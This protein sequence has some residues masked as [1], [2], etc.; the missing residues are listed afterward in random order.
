MPKFNFKTDEEFQPTRLDKYLAGMISELSRSKIKELILTNCVQVNSKIITDP[1]YKLLPHSDLEMEYEYTHTNTLAPK[2]IPLDI[3]Y[4][5]DDLIVINKQSGLTVHPG[6]GNYNDTL[7]NALAFYCGDNL[8]NVGGE[9]RP[10]I[11]HRLDR[12]TSGLMIVAKNNYAHHR[13]SKALADRLISRKYAAFIYKSLSP[14]V[15]KITTGY[16]KS[17][18][19][20]TKMVATFAKDKL[21][22]TN[23]KTLEEFYDG[24]LS[25]VEFALETGRTHQIRFHLEHMKSK[26]I[27]DKVYGKS[28][29]FNLSKVPVEVLE[30]IAK[31]D[32]QLLHSYNLEFSHP[33]TKELMKFKVGYPKEIMELLKLIQG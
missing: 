7:V 19:D 25:L 11:V 6:A 18:R 17:N 9:A 31:V 15:G 16:R 14:G 8:S 32:R 29:N 30:G 26:L 33:R 4:E 21:A 20:H 28:L 22:I 23:Y 10:G 27:G 13:L 24:S 2:N 1:A 5:D 3:V 12:D